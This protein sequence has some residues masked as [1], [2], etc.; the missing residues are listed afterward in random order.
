MLTPVQMP[1][2]LISS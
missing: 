1:Q 2:T